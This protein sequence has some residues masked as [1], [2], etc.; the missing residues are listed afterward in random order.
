EKALQMAVAHQPVSIALEAGGRDFQHYKSGIF[1]GKCGT[2][3]DHGVVAAGYG[4]EN[5][6]DYW[7]VRNSWGAKWGEKGYLRVQR[8]VA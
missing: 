2:A 3:V 7:I 4:T 8:N 6:M 5:G 1:T